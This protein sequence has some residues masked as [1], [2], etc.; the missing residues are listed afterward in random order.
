MS[1]SDSAYQRHC[2]RKHQSVLMGQIAMKRCLQCGQ[3]YGDNTRARWSDLNTSDVPATRLVQTHQNV[4]RT[5]VGRYR[6]LETRPGRGWVR[7]IRIRLAC[8]QNSS[9]NV[10][11]V[12]EFDIRQTKRG[13]SGRT[14]WARRGS[15]GGG[16]KVK[17]ETITATFT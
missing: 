3:E 14:S 13:S 12:S 10:T 17:I 11:I 6:L 5:L 9:R 4:G 2:R 8:T 7:F 15:I 1:D 16:K